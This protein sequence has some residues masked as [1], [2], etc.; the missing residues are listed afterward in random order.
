MK[1]SIRKAGNSNRIIVPKSFLESFLIKS[2]VYIDVKDY[3]PII[4]NPEDIKRAGWEQ[5]FENMAVNGDDQ[6]VIPYL[7]KNEEIFDWTW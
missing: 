3:Y 7:F 4:R 5:A 6:L 2:G 1:P